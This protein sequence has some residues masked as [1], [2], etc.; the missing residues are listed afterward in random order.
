MWRAVSPVIVRSSRSAPCF[1]RSRTSS[2]LP[3]LAA[4]WIRRVPTGDDPDVE[5]LAL[6]R[7]DARRGE[8]RAEERV[9]RDLGGDP[10]GEPRGRRNPRHHHVVECGSAG[11]D[12]GNAGQAPGPPG[13]REEHLGLHRELPRILA[14]SGNRDVRAGSR[15]RGTQEHLDRVA[16]HLDRE[17]RDARVLPPHRQDRDAVGN[18]GAHPDRD[19]APAAPDDVLEGGSRQFPAL[20]NERGPRRA[21]RGPGGF[22]VG[23]P[24]G[25]DPRPIRDEEEREGVERRSAVDLRLGEPDSTRPALPFHS[26]GSA[27]RDQ[28][29][30]RRR[31]GPADRGPCRG[32]HRGA[33]GG[34]DEQQG[35]QGLDDA[36][37]EAARRGGDHLLPE[38]ERRDRRVLSPPAHEMQDHH[39]DGREEQP[40]EIG[41]REAH[42]ITPPRRSSVR[43][44]CEKSASERSRAW[45]ISLPTA[46]RSTRRQKP[47]H[48]SS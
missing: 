9:R 13:E 5:G 32:Q 1:A 41:T 3:F 30:S 23:R 8:R 39:R 34:K 22:N 16:P 40:E 48:R 17:V 24:R 21:Q 47:R 11:A 27:D 15:P 25:E 19:G 7:G 35:H 44:A 46:Y 37:P 36:R 26:G 43:T 4:V 28:E 29:R 14:V 18:L 10:D 38:D 6:R 42:R 20:A 33:E 31:R 2:G 45:P 12:E